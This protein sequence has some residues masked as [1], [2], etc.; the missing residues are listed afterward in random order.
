MQESNTALEPKRPKVGWLSE[1]WTAAV[2]GFVCFLLALATAWYSA[3]ADFKWR[4]DEAPKGTKWTHVLKP[5][6]GSGGAWSHDPRQCLWSNQFE[7]A[8]NPSAAITT[9]AETYWPGLIGAAAMLSVFSAIGA[10]L[11]G[12]RMTK[13]FPAFCPIFLLAVLAMVMAK[14]ESIRA[15]GLEY[16]LWAVLL[17]LLISNSIGTPTSWRPA[18]MAELYIKLGLVMLG[19]EVLFG[20]LVVYG[21]RG[22]FV[23]WVVTP[24]V[25]ISTYLFGQYVLKMSSR[26]LNIVIS[27]DMSVCGVSAAIATAAA[28]RAKRDEL[29]LAIGLSLAFTM[30]MM[31]VLPQICSWL[32]LSPIVAGAWIGGTIDSTGA[33]AAAGTMVGEQAREAAVMIKMIQNTLIGVIALAVATYWATV[34]EPQA[35]SESDGGNVPN[36]S[37]AAPRNSPGLS[38]IWR[39]FPK[40]ILGFLAVSLVA[41]WIVE[42]GAFENLWLKDAVQGGV[43]VSLRNWL[44]CLGFVCIGLDSNLRSFLPHLRTGK[45]VV[46]YVVGQSLNL[47]LTLAMAYLMFEVLA[48][49]PEVMDAG[50]SP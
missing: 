34:V 15:L 20:T 29:S 40:F 30:V 41:S 42:Q 18:V 4:A 38:E 13:F 46:L 7:P 49:N 50:G 12:E 19:A 28:C 32:D 23:A 2:L 3:P 9:K 24:I 35:E 1:D 44:F 17:G 36:K 14:Q 6:L 33:V 37:N 45:P 10:A 47:V 31:V 21:V 8:A 26:T 25:L 39:R 16:V 48:P 43:T 11:R 5:Y 22:I 27:A